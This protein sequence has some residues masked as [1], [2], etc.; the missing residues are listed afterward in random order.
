MYKIK[1]D[2]KTGDSFSTNDESDFVKGKDYKILLFKNIDI[3][4]ENLLRIKQHYDWQKKYN[5]NSYSMRWGIS[6]T[7]KENKEIAK[8]PRNKR[9]KA[10]EKI[11]LKHIPKF[12]KYRSKDDLFNLEY[13]I[14]LLDDNK[15]EVLCT[16]F[17]VGYFET[18]YGASIVADEED[19][20]SF[21][22]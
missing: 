12:M 15:N 7:D 19:G 1:V 3:A 9:D 17:W 16:C 22:V 8:L 14:N 18:L 6:L 21:T 2:Y 11:Y 20:W 10:Y 5:P 13:Y 4:K